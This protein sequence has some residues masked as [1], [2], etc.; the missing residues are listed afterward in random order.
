MIYFLK[1]GESRYDAIAGLG[2][3][4]G[5]LD[6][7]SRL[8]DLPSSTRSLHDVTFDYSLGLS[9]ELA[10]LC[11]TVILAG[12]VTLLAWQC[13]ACPLTS[14]LSSF[15]SDFGLHLAATVGD[16]PSFSRSYL[17][18]IPEL[19]GCPILPFFLICCLT[20]HY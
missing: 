14:A 18:G 6:R 9:T 1:P 10:C 4:L 17:S 8:T 5:C 20:Y 12:R 7:D 15:S 16:L 3:G 19:S 2:Y 11:G 13:G